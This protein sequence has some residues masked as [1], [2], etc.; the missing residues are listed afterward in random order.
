MKLA[1]CILVCA[2]ALA[3][4]G[5]S[6]APN[7]IVVQRFFG[8][9]DAEYGRA[10]DVSAAEG[11][12]GIITTLLNRFSA[13]NPDIRVTVSIVPWPGYNQLSA[14]LGA[15]DAP[16]V[17]TMH[18]SAIPDFQSRGLLEPME[19]ALRAVG[20][21]PAEFTEASLKGVTKEGRIYGMPFDTWAMLWHVNMN[22]FREAGLVE[23]GRPILPHS[24]EELL[25]HARQF[26]QATGKPYFVQ[27]MANQKPVY[28]RNLYTY[29]MQQDAA[30]FADP[31]HIRLQ[32]PEARRVVEMF[33][34]IS[35]E[36]LTTKN[37]DYAAAT[38]G[39][40]N[41]DGGVYMVGTWVIGIYEA[42]SRKADRPLS[43]GYTVMPYPQLFPG[44]DASFVDGHAWVMP[45]KERTQLQR[46]AVFRLMK[47]LAE[48]DFEWARTGHLPA[49]TDVIQ[50]A[51]FK[52]LPHRQ[53]IARLS[54][55]GA[56]LP[57]DVERQFAIQDIIGEELA[58]AIDGQ[59]SI[60]DALADAE[61]RINELL[62]HLL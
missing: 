29:L 58:P 6:Q 39:F 37:Q 59:K 38:R 14:Q 61:H 50:S 26:K 36:N 32:T 55:T 16:D 53:N 1:G 33:K 8:A 48:N 23:N 44:R 46:D 22:Y 34:A 35:D 30:I 47:F 57:S 24:P 15:D 21:D 42:E 49:F 41:G 56:P 52:A 54:T 12:C 31:Q 11:E 19:D 3:G 17:V 51:R 27:A 25:A 18:E 7:E 45:V 62:F 5:V 9:C 10:L 60:D 28:A 40:M 4:C 2:Q 20:V 43:G 13:E